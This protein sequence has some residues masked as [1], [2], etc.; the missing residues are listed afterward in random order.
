MLRTSVVVCCPPDAQAQWA[1]KL[2]DIEQQ[3]WTKLQEAQRLAEASFDERRRM[4]EAAR[5]AWPDSEQ[6]G[7][8][9]APARTQDSNERLLNDL[10][11]DMRQLQHSIQAEKMRQKAAYQSKL[12]SRMEQRKRRILKDAAHGRKGLVKDGMDKQTHLLSQQLH[13]QRFLFS[14]T[15]TRQVRFFICNV[16]GRGRLA[17]RARHRLPESS[18]PLL[19]STAFKKACFRGMSKSFYHRALSLFTFVMGALAYGRSC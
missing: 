16:R 3:E 5:G 9:P 14:R 10:M 2:R 17:R 8:E 15:K 13:Q 1:Q 6:T 12:L 19:R 18:M 11:A 4:I 7:G